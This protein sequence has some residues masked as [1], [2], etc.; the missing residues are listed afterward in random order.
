MVFI[1]FD[2]S[3]EWQNEDSVFDTI[4]MNLVE[5][6]KSSTTEF[7]L[8]EFTANLNF[9]KLLYFEKYKN[10][11]LFSYSIRVSIEKESMC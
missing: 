7:W 4:Y 10:L 8:L 1:L 5:V 3:I 9:A 6:T 11:S 2:N